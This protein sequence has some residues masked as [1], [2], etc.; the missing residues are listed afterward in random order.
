MKEIWTSS[1]LDGLADER[2][3]ESGDRPDYLEGSLGEGSERF[4]RSFPKDV[5]KVYGT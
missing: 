1:N 5:S 2:G 3:G 4:S